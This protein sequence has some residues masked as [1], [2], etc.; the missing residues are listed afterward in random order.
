LDRGSV[1]AMLDRTFPGN[2][3]SKGAQYDWLVDVLH[4]NG[5]NTVNDAERMFKSANGSELARRMGYRF[6]A[7]QVRIADDFLLQSLGEDYVAATKS[8]GE[9]ANREGK[10]RSRLR[11]MRL[12]RDA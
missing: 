9:D 6:P 4:S 1:Q 12:A 2:P 5:A 11:K 3:R 7:G 10:L 8:L